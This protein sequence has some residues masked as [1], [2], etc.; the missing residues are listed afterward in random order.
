LII[1]ELVQNAVEHAFVGLP[2][3]SIVVRLAEQGDSLYIEIHDDGRGLP[4]D[5]DPARQGGLGMQIVR[6][7]VREDLKG[8]FELL[9]KTDGQGV[10]A[11]VSFP[12][13]RAKA[14]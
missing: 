6:S 3:G 4:P 7:L 12:K 2:G 1:N 14:E 5:F 9:Q 8:E 10:H 11:I 13:W